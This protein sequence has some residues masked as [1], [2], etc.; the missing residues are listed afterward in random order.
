[1]HIGPINTSSGNMTNSDAE[2][3]NSFNDHFVNVFTA[4]DTS[5][6]PLP[7]NRFVQPNRLCS[8]ISFTQQDVLD[9]LTKLRIDTAD[10][11]DE[12]SARFLTEIKDHIVYPLFIIFR[13]SLDEGSVPDDWKSAN[14]SPIFKKGNRN[15]ADN[16][17]PVSLT[18]LICK[19]FESIIRDAVVRHL[20]DNS[21]LRDSQHGF[22][23][24]RS[25]LTNLLTF[26]DKVTG[27]LDSGVPVDTVFLDF[28]KAFDKVP[29]RRLALKLESHGISGKLLQWI[30]A[31]LSNR[32]QRVCINGTKSSWQLVLSGVP[33]GSVLG[34][35]LFLIYINDLDDGIVNSILKFADDTKIFGAVSDLGQHRQL[36]EDLNTLLQWSKD[37]QMLFHIDKC[38]VMHF[39]HNNLKLDYSLDNKTLQK[40]HQEKDLGVIISDDMKSSL[41]CIQAYSKANK[42]LGVINRAIVYKSKEVMLSLYKTLVRPHLEYCTVAW[43]PHYVKDRVLL[44]RVQRRFTRMVPELKGLSYPDRLKKLGLWSLEER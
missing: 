40:V 14:I 44:E 17:R 7:A 39:G 31:W 34:P 27:Y 26:M 6:I 38:K 13:K 8:D 43:S 36:Q 2:L 30:V 25:C 15:M 20:E 29:H 10:G 37:W 32:K 35:L 22:R 9:V 19:M 12:L 16:Y 18:S 41:Q 1:V 23:K 5:S 3:V 24:G 4:E 11:P 33:Q 28:A 21:L 42:M